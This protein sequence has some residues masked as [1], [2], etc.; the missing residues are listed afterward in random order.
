[1]AAI[2]VGASDVRTSDAQGSP[3]R[4]PPIRTLPVGTPP[5]RARVG[6]APVGR[7]SSGPAW[8][9]RPVRLTR[10]GRLVVVAALL[11]VATVPVA[12]AAGRG[13]AAGP[14]GPVPTIVVQPGDTLWSVAARTGPGRDRFRVIDEIRRLNAIR[15]YTVH[16]GQRLIVP[17]THGAGEIR[18]G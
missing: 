12:L 17:R 10:R 9:A 4:T 2:A 6:G 8:S 7:G 15:D 16:P 14:A 3:V 13:E 5:V 11:A 18:R 1:M